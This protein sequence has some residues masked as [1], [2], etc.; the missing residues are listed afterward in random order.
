MLRSLLLPLVFLLAGCGGEADDG[1]V[2]IE[3]WAMGREGEVVQ[4]LIPDFERE[5]PGIRVEV[6]QLPWTSAHEKLLTAF[7]G[8]STPD[9]CQLGN[10]WVPEMEALG[11]IEN[12]SP[13]VAQSEVIEQADYFPGIW[14]TNVLGGASYG[15][16]WYVDTRLLFY[17]SDILQAAGYDAVPDDWA[18][19]LEAMR[20]VRANAGPEQYAVLLPLNEFEPLLILGLQSGDL[21]RDGNRYGAFSKPGFRRAFQLYV[22]L[23][24]EGLAPPVTGAQISNVWQEFEN[25]YFT[26]YVTGPWNIGEFRRRLSPEMDGKW[27][28][29]PMP[30]PDGP[31]VSVAGG[32]SLAIFER[33]EHKAEAWAFVEYLSRPD[34]QVRFHEITGNLPARESA[35][36]DPVLAENDYAAAFRDQLR[37][38]RPTPK[39]PEQE[40][41]AQKIREYA[42]FAASG[43]L[44]V[45]EALAGLDRDVDRILDKRRWLLDQQQEARRE[46]VP[47]AAP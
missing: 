28:T 12:L 39:I 33:S 15:V 37:R 14:D 26:F 7:A 1:V 5:H 11:A 25:G 47:E 45:D 38:V 42:E 8:R 41:I 2:T 34:I 18:G 13:W 31:G 46:A 43:R 4:E 27:M 24:E 21:L 44:T 32:A 30:G 23:F 19:W 40:R 17:R 29:A 22:D 35:W 10:T 6:Q 20:A 36:A 3:F 9:L 16:P